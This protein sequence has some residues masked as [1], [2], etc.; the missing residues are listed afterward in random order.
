LASNGVEHFLLSE[1]PQQ[2]YPINSFTFGWVCNKKNMLH[3]GNF[4]PLAEIPF[5]N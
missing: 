4:V 2:K 3:Q 1:N 5:F